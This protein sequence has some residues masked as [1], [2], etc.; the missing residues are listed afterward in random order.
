MQH[1]EQRG[2][3]ITQHLF[4]LILGMLLIIGMIGCRHQSPVAPR[5]QL[6]APPPGTCSLNVWPSTIVFSVTEHGI[7]IIRCGKKPFYIMSIIPGDHFTAEIWED[8]LFVKGI[9]YHDFGRIYVRD[10]SDQVAEV[11]VKTR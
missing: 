5:N 2:F 7:G 11:Q 10:Q 9:Y 4:S 1:V 3:I 8:R 6:P